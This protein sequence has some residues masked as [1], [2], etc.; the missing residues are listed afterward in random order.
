VKLP[1]N[2]ET[3]KLNPYVHVLM[4]KSWPFICVLPSRFSLSRN[5]L[6]GR[7]GNRMTYKLTISILD[8]LF[9]SNLVWC[10][11]QNLR[12]IRCHKV[13]ELLNMVMF[14]INQPTRCNNFS[15]LLLDVYLY[16]QRNMF[17]VS[18]RSSSGAQQLQ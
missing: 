9:I 6:K 8:L 4:I 17:R 1:V 15:S 3:M 12:C 16:V 13:T 10:S 7:V 14:Q 11:D 2:F 18:L 5:A